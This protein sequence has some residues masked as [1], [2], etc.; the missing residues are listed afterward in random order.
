MR[1]GRSARGVLFELAVFVSGGLLGS[2]LTTWLAYRRRLARQPRAGGV[3]AA[4]APPKSI[5]VV[6]DV[7]LDMIAKVGRLPR[8]NADCEIERPIETHA[9]GS[10]LNTAVQLASLISTRT[11]KEAWAAIQQ[12]PPPAAAAAAAAATAA[13]T[14]PPATAATAARGG[15]AVA[16]RLFCVERCVLHSLIGDDM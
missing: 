12:P 9:G 1:A 5:H 11:D 14:P 8:F 6:G 2:L 7:Y 4:P 13:T 10:A 3:A 15:R 16:R